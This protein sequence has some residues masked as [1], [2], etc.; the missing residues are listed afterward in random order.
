MPSTAESHAAVTDLRDYDLQEAARTHGARPGSL[1]WRLLS[2]LQSLR[3]PVRGQAVDASALRAD[4][5]HAPE[6]DVTRRYSRRVFVR[7]RAEP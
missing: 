7:S 6:A 2:E 1:L 5:S 4:G 3:H